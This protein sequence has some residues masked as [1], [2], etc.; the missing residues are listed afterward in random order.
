MDGE[1]FAQRRIEGGQFEAETGS[2]QPGGHNSLAIE[3]QLVG[4]LPHQQA[5][6]RGR[7]RRAEKGSLVSLHRATKP[8]AG[9]RLRRG[10]IERAGEVAALL[11]ETDRR[12]H[13]LSMHP[14][15]PLLPAAQPAAY[16]ELE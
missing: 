8:A 9:D 11:Q 6:N 2:F 1:D 3:Q 10:D 14:A 15:E 16:S 4:H 7:H 12:Y 5:N 13:I